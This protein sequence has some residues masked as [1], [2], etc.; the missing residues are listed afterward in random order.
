[1]K[2][3][4]FPPLA[5]PPAAQQTGQPPKPKSQQPAVKSDATSPQP[6]SGGLNAW[7]SMP[8]ERQ[9]ESIATGQ[10]SNRR[11]GG[12]VGGGLTP[13]Q[14]RELA[15]VLE[16]REL[17]KQTR[18]RPAKKK[19][20]KRKKQPAAPMVLNLQITLDAS[21]SAKLA[22]IFSTLS[23]TQILSGSFGNSKELAKTCR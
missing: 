20:A 9:P 10:N 7:L 21:Q 16:R 3:K 15:A 14:Y 13:R 5:G 11:E 8:S 4:N 22:K 18:E 1:M 12:D 17:G 23:N 2:S 6:H 19:L